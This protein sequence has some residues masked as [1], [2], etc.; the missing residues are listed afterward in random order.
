MTGR[1]RPARVLSGRVAT[2]VGKLTKPCPRCGA[3]VGWRC[4]WYIGSMWTPIKSI[5]KE[6]R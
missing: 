3:A 4:G 1:L 6:R 2:T 5:H